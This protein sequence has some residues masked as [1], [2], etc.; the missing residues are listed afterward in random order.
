MGQAA[1]TGLADLTRNLNTQIGGFP[2]FGG[3]SLDAP[4]MKDFTSAEGAAAK[5]AIDAAFQA[6]FGFASNDPSAASLS[7]GDMQNF[8]DGPFSTL[9]QGSNWGALW[10][11]ASAA[12]MQG[13]VAPGIMAESNTT[14]HSQGI[15]DLAKGY[16][17]LAYFKNMPVTDVAY[18]GLVDAS[19]ISVGTARGGLTAAQ[20]NLG[21]AEERV[22]NATTRLSEMET[23]FSRSLS[24]L[25]ATDPFDVAQ[26]IN[27]LLTGIEATYAMTARLQR[28]SL[29]NF[30]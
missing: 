19:L 6:Q 8:F 9:F 20:A 26:R 10:S 22:S 5:A 17:A 21:L 15:Q 30:L 1:T 16:V 3:Q 13:E 29:V 11:N 24:D 23:V 28:L 25:E 14:T 2:I 27:T 4:P 12:P 7:A 18:K